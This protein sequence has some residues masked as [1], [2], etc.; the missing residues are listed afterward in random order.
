MRNAGHRAGGYLAGL[1]LLGSACREPGGVYQPGLAYQRC[2]VHR[3]VRG[4]C[5][6]IG[7]PALTGRM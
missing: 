4:Y 6:E 3:R 2:G 7:D 5:R 1:H